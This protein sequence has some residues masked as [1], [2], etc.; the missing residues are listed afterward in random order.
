M[1]REK[2]PE[3]FSHDLETT[4][5][6]V[7]QAWL[8]HEAKSRD[9]AICPCCVRELR[10]TSFKLNSQLARLLIICYRTYGVGACVDIAQMIAACKRADLVKGR[11]WNKLRYWGLLELV[12]RSF[13]PTSK[14]SDLCRLTQ[15]GQDFVYRTLRLPK[16]IWV[17][18]HELVA[19]ESSAVSI[20]DVLGRNHDFNQ[21]MN[22]EYYWS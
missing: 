13:V 2:S 15:K 4:P 19:A 3:V 5:I 20:Q 9:G 10:Y 7:G 1:P 6:A 8:Q 21:L 14:P 12:D 16:T 18:D 17:H 11:E 22:E